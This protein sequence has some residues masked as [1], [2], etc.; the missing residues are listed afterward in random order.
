M[1]GASDV[2]IKDPAVGGANQGLLFEDKY[3]TEIYI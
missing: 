2:M 1:G 3:S